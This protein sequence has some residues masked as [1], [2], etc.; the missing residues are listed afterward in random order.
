ALPLFQ[1]AAVIRDVFLKGGLPTVR[2]ELKPIDMD[3]QLLQII[4]DVDGQIVKYAH[5]PQIPVTVSWPGTRGSNQVRIQYSVQGSS[6]TVSKV[7]EG[8]WA[9]F[10]ALDA[11]QIAPGATP[12]KL[13]ASFG[14]IGAQASDSKSMRWGYEIPL[15]C[16]N[17]SPSAARQGFDMSAHIRLAGCYGKLPGLGDFLS[18]R[19]DPGFVAAWDRWLQAGLQ[20]SRAH[21]GQQWSEC[22]L[23]A[24]IWRFALAPGLCGERA[25]LGIL[26]PSVD[27]VGRYFPFSILQEVTAMWPAA[28]AVAE[29]GGWFDPGR[30][31]GTCRLE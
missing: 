17:Y 12:E 1:K 3:A 6:E 16:L 7:F 10:R 20:D 18:R 11:A 29:A 14:A 5:G 28:W 4:I 21:L 27:S 23:N 15:N 25:M 24:P 22:Y 31:G 8:P 9:L 26:M 2:V 30:T 13:H 19:L